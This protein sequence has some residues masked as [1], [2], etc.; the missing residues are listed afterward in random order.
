M[1]NMLVDTADPERSFLP[2]KN[3]SSDR[4][5]LLVNNLG[6]VSELEMGAVAL[7]ALNDL[8]KRNITVV[9][10]LVGTFMVSL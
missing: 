2:F 1:I 8:R 3:D 10:V 6:A 9:K 4:V 7:A 5:V